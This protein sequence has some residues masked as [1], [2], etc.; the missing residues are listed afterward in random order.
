MSGR[1]D[2]LVIGAGPAGTSTAI[3]LAGAGWSSAIAEQHRFPRAKVCGECVGAGSL[4]LLDEVGVG[5]AFRRL[6]GPPLRRVGWM[7]AVGT[8]IADL[9]SCSG[10]PYPFGRALG[11]DQLDDLLLQRAKALGVKV[12]QP[13]KVRSIRG[14]PGGFACDIESM[15]DSLHRDR[16]RPRTMQTVH[17]RVIIDAHGSWE[18]GPDSIPPDPL[19]KTPWPRREADLFGFKAT[20]LGTT[21]PQSLLPVLALDG[22]YGGIVVSDHGRTTLACCIRRDTLRACRTRTP[23]ASAGEAVEAYLRRSCLGVHEAL[24]DAHRDG[25]WLAVGPLRPGIHI[26]SAHG[27]FRVGNA[28]GESHPLI[29]EGISMALQSAALLARTLTQHPPWAISGSVAR[30]LQH[31]YAVAWRREFTSRLRFAAAYANLAM[32][33]GLAAPTRS[34]LR[35][36]PGLLTV[37]ARLAGKAQRPVPTGSF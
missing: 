37:A 14:G 5:T 4:L 11:R 33:P 20:F 34:M 25:A 32:R 7:S 35:R 28:A 29:G 8:I 12:L 3:R 21:L 9:P 6:A 17:A 18:P 36:W 2:A 13:V 31:T 16:R 24:L 30:Q 27:L 22:G 26:N 23:G 10:G 19:A 1:V 15:P